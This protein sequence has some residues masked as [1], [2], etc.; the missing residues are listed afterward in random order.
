MLFLRTNHKFVQSG[1]EEGRRR[2]P[3]FTSCTPAATAVS[4]RIIIIKIRRNRDALREFGIDFSA[5]IGKMSPA[6]HR[7]RPVVIVQLTKAR[8]QR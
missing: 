5:I 6:G 3:R 2:E 8:A 1:D 7:D 4:L